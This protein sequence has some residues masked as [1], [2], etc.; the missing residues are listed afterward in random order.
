[1][2]WQEWTSAADNAS[3]WQGREEKGLLKAEHLSDYVLRLWFQD[4]LDVSLYELDFY[5][6]VVEENPGGVF[7]PLK[8]KERFQQVRGEY[9]LIWPNPET[10]AYDEHAIDIA[11]ECV[12]FF[13]E[14]YG[15]PL[16]V[17]EKRMAPS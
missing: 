12:R 14:R 5:P 7:A 2:K 9:A 10:G 1:M 6:L 15:N 3:L 16:K 8:D 11:P 4:G 13:C 17:A